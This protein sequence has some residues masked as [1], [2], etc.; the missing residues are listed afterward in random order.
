MECRQ[1]TSKWSL[2]LTIYHSRKD[3]DTEN[4]FDEIGYIN[5]EYL[6]KE[7]ID[8]NTFTLTANAANDALICCS[9][10]NILSD[11]NFHGLQ[12]KCY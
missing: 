3:N 11:Q 6:K 9:L 1:Y 5:M 4:D 7:L 10:L 2:F 8:N 12:Q